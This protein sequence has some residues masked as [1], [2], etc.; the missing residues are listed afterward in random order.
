MLGKDT[1]FAFVVVNG[2]IMFGCMDTA[3]ICGFGATKVSVEVDLL[4]GLPTFQVVGLAENSVKEARVRVQSSIVNAGLAFPKGKVFVNLAPADVQ[5]N[6][7]CFD[8]SMALA[9][10]IATGV[11]PKIRT[12]GIAAIGELS[13]TGQIRPVR[14]ML[15]LAE[16]IK[17]QGCKILLVAAENAHEAHLIPGLEIKIADNLAEVVQ[18]IVH[19]DF[20]SLK[21]PSLV[22]PA[23]EP[24]HLH[25]MEDVIGQEEARRALLIAAAGDHNVVLVG[26]P[27]S[28]KSMMAHRLPSI[29]PPLRFQDAI[30]LTKIYSLAGLT[31][32]GHLIDRRP[33]R[34][35]HHSTTRAGLTGGG[36]K[37]IRP[38]EISLACFGVLFLDELLEFPRAVLEVLRQPLEDGVITLSRAN[39]TVSYPAQV[40]LIAAFNPCPCGHYGQKGHHCNCSASTIERYQS[41]VSGPLAD[42]IDLFVNVVPV[43]LRLMHTRGQS[44]TSRSMRERVMRARARQE[45]RFGLTN[46]KMSRRHIRE[47]ALLTGEAHDYLVRCAEKLLLSARAYDRIIKVARTIAD[48]DE[49]KEI[50]IPHVAEALHFRRSAALS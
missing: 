16:C 23:I 44:E 7:T 18:A 40:S 10:L 19:G 6:G 28:G 8:L 33:F 22:A 26:G 46:G 14:G 30:L 39:I 15:S 48:L 36:S 31:L 11:V 50:A 24:V 34:A 29:L 17:E 2:G 27:G 4:K 41:R 43:N 20:S 38:G 49:A 42:R 13:L 35:P 45:Q 3:A 32:S 47:A 25:D 12:E 37:L 1:D 5:K 9:I 21:D